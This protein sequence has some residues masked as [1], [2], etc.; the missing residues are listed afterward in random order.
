MTGARRSWARRPEQREEF[1][2]HPGRAIC[3]ASM[4][5][6]LVLAAAL[7]V[8]AGPLT[9]DSRWSG[10]MQDIESPFLTHL[11][12][13]FDALGHGI[14]RALT[15]AAIGLVLL[16]ARR[17]A[18]LIAFALVEALTPLLGNLIKV[19]V[20]RP[21]PPGRL[22]DAY[23]SSF[24][25]GH[26]A[27]ASATAIALVLLFSTP[28]ARRRPWF[29]AAAVI[30]G[31]AWSRTYLQAHW[32]SDVVAGATLGLAVALAGFGVVQQ[33]ER[34]GG[35]APCAGGSAPRSRSPG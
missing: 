22:L 35:S 10:L 15:L 6:A 11:A 8:P 2:A 1:L 18:A 34:L 30:A 21:R 13:V 27:Y 17:W 24:P 5:L 19:L 31:M 23:G 7:L 26:A 9:L 28:G 3:W 16:V 4:L 25:S 33:A 20:D 29:A 14:W 12:L 32:L